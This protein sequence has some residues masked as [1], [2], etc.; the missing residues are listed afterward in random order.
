MA[1]F[2]IRSY[3]T[4]ESKR[5]YSPT[6]EIV[7]GGQVL[8]LVSRGAAKNPQTLKALYEAEGGRQSNI[9]AMATTMWMATLQNRPELSQVFTKLDR[10]QTAIDYIAD[11]IHRYFM[12]SELSVLPENPH[13]LVREL[14]GSKSK[15]ALK[16]LDRLSQDGPLFG[17]PQTVYSATIVD[18]AAKDAEKARII[19][20]KPEVTEADLRERY[21]MPH[22]VIR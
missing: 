19:P 14:Y 15:L 13:K 22:V 3:E 9:H 16:L 2:D 8:D 18:Q 10:I 12:D 7:G 17:K 1:I 4:G 21:H 5:R 11:D 20:A 6:T